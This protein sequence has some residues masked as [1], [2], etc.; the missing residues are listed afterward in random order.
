MLFPSLGWLAFVCVAVLL[1][2]AS[3][4]ED[5]QADGVITGIVHTKAPQARPIRITT[6][7]RVCGTE[8][9]DESVT[10]DAKGNLAYAVVSLAGVKSPA[11]AASEAVIVNS[12]CRFVPRVQVARPGA[13]V[14]VR[15]E[16]AILHNTHLQAESGASIFNVGLPV[17]GPTISRRL[18]GSGRVRIGCNVHPWMRGWIIATDARATV[19]GADGKFRLQGIPAGTYELRIWHEALAEELRQVT[20]AGGQVA[21]LT[22]EMKTK[23]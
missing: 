14:K 16:D 2:L 23:P 19:T 21:D 1:P 3:A 4:A 18:A 22:V 20:V 9:P 11:G 10:V 7:Q 15:S 12:K 8:L 17:P 5:L 13:V 6:D